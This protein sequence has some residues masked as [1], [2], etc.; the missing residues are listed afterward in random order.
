MGEMG[1]AKIGDDQRRTHDSDMSD[2]S[3]ALDQ[4]S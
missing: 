3:T 4:N 2:I 1:D